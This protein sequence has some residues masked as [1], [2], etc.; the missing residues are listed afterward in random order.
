MLWSRRVMQQLC[1]L[2]DSFHGLVKDVGVV[3]GVEVDKRSDAASVRLRGDTHT[4]VR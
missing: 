2:T 4:H 3:L 1:G